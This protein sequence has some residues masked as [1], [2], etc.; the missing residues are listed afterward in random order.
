MCSTGNACTP[1]VAW[2]AAESRVWLERAAASPTA[3]GGGAACE[4][5][6]LLLAGAPPDVPAAL[7][8]L[9]AAMDRGSAAAAPA[10]ARVL[11][12]HPRVRFAPLHCGWSAGV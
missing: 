12:M 3:E 8:L 5:A 10:L 6:E 4:L 1:S 2:S 9:E 7:K 11:G